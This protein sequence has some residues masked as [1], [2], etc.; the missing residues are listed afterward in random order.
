MLKFIAG[1][2]AGAGIALVIAPARGSVLR[3]RVRENLVELSEMPRK[4]ATE[5]LDRYEE[6]ISRAGEQLG[7]QVAE[8]AVGKV[9]DQLNQR[10]TA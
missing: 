8:A 6:K 10:E 4:K 9:K 5:L 1:L 2:A 7:R 3:R